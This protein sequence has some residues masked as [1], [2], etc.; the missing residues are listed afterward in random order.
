[1][2][3]PRSRKRSPSR[4]ESAQPKPAQ[5]DPTRGGSDDAVQ[6]ALRLLRHRDRSVAQVD[7][8]LQARGFEDDAR[9]EALAT[10]GRTGIVDDTRFAELRATTLAERGAG[11]ALIAHDLTGAGIAPDAVDGAIAALESEQERARRAVQRRGATPKTARYLAGKGFS[12]DVVREV[13][14]RAG[15][16]ALG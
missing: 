14:A 16:E 13:V 3:T 10:L 11:N 6:A 12:E 2:S 1:L 9:A 8:E 7:R 5:P 15:D 4:A